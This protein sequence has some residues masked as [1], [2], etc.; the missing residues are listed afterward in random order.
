MLPEVRPDNAR[1]VRVEQGWGRANACPSAPGSPTAT[2]STGSTPTCCRAASTSRPSCAGTTRST[3]PWCSATSGS[4]TRRR[5]TASRR[6]RCAT[7]WPRDR[8]DEYF[9]ADVL[10]PH[11]W[12]ERY[13]SR[14]DD[15]RTI[16]PRACRIHVGATASL[17]RD[18]YRDSGGM[19]TTLKL[20]EDISLGY[21][22]GEAG[23]VFLPDREARSWH[24]GPH[25]RDDPPRRG[26]RLQR[27]LPVRPAPRAAQQAA[28]R[29][30]VRRPL[31]RGR[32]RHDRPAA[33]ARSSPPSTRCSSGTLPD[34]QVTLVGR[35]SDLDDTP[36]PPARRPDARHPAGPGVVRRR[37]PR[38]AG[39]VAARGPLPGDVPDDPRERRVGADPQDRWPGCS[40]TSS[41]PTTGSGSSGCPTAPPRASSAPLPS[42]GPSTSIKSGEFLDDVLDELFGAWTFE[43]A[44]VG[45]W[46]CHE[47][48]RAAHAGHRRRGRGPGHRVGP[49]RRADRAQPQ[50][51]ARRPRPAPARKAAGPRRPRPTGHWSAPCGTGWRP[52]W[53]AGDGRC[54]SRRPGRTPESAPRRS[55]QAPRGVRGRLRPQRH[56][57]DVGRAADPGHARP[58]ARGASPTR[59]TPRASASRSG[60]STSTPSCSQR[61]NVAVSDARPAAWFEAGKLANIERLRTAPARP[62]WRSSSPTRRP[63]A[64]RQGPAAGVVPRACGGRPRCAARP[65]R[66]TSP[67]C[68]P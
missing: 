30:P 56:Q 45:F 63:R 34:L 28:G 44:E 67:C 23:A 61:C 53:G 65:R 68:G 64:G 1:I 24:L 57:H 41:A 55:A 5:S 40:T 16:G 6:P 13:Y 26:Q 10:E 66:R 25:P 62:G 49:H 43:A 36:H 2:S 52:C 12:V 31:P 14:F 7:P 11:E 19:D 58:A 4:S 8:M 20:G 51:R 35:W 22:L 60:S 47:V 9:P 15:L 46:P 37:P 59:P 48:H 17:A 54:P 21:R 18:L 50:G 38:A 42:R 27:L 39:R 33:T 3:T 29:P 32:P